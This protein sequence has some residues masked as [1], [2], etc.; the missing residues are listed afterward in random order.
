MRGVQVRIPRIRSD[1]PVSDVTEI[2]QAVFG[3]KHS[4]S[5]YT[6]GHD[7]FSI[8]HFVHKYMLKFLWGLQS[9]GM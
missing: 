3:V 5:G 9:S 2:R 8:L 4:D 7:L 6:K 1:L